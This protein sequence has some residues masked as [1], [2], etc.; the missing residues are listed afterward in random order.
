[1]EYEDV[2]KYLEADPR[3]RERTNKNKGLANMIIMKYSQRLNGIDRDLLAEICTKF[4]SADRSWRD[5][6]K[7]N[8]NLR[9]TDYDEKAELEEQKQ[10]ELGYK[11][12]SS[13]KSLLA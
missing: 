11:V 12:G 8:P 4:S 7:K 1:M 10:S 5:I 9:G 2:K 6:L 13:R 3:F